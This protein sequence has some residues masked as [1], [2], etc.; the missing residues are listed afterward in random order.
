[1]SDKPENSYKLTPVG[2]AREFRVS[3][4]MGFE[5]P[6]A[7][8]TSAREP[9]T[10]VS[11]EERYPFA[12]DEVLEALR[13]EY[14]RAIA[15]LEDL[16]SDLFHEP[17]DAADA[18]FFGSREEQQ[19]GA[20]AELTEKYS[21]VTQA[22]GQRQD[23]QIY[24]PVSFAEAAAYEMEAPL[25]TAVMLALD[26]KEQDMTYYK[27]RLAKEAGLQDTFG[28]IAAIAAQMPPT[29]GLEDFAETLEPCGPMVV[30]TTEKIRCSPEDEAARLRA[31]F[32]DAD[33]PPPVIQEGQE[34]R[35]PYPID[36]VLEAVEAEADQAV[37]FY[38]Q[39]PQLD[40]G[41]MNAQFT[42][43]TK[44]EILSVLSKARDAGV[45]EV[46]L[47]LKPNSDPNHPPM[48]VF[49]TVF[50]NMLLSGQD[51]FLEPPGSAGPAMG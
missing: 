18:I 14:G 4:D 51:R 33:D 23:R 46:W 34:V 39:N 36:R 15:L 43:G 27:E 42:H 50:H 11:W 30:V 17:M 45:P 37:A 7:D 22:L 5:V 47:A 35:L 13:Q 32:E 19:Q 25:L 12:V 6:Q 21:A 38:Q 44:E 41:G 20:V 8:G 26:L 29:F 24:L 10:V 2:E 40:P 3:E 28:A 31:I 9:R 48:R 16:D 49:S 1:M